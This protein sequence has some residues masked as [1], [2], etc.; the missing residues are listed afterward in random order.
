MTRGPDDVKMTGKGDAA[1]RE[2]KLL[3]ALR[4]ERLEVPP[5]WLMRQAGRYLPEYRELRARAGSFL[6]LCYNPALAAEVTLQP[7]TRFGLDAAI[8]FSDILILPHA[9]GQALRFDEGR[10]PVLEPI[11]DSAALDNLRTEDI[12]ARLG[13]VYEA[14]RRIAVALPSETAFIGFAGAPWT[15]AT[16]MVEGSGSRDFFHAKGW[17]YR[18]PAGF[19]RLIDLLVA[20]TADHLIAQID[21]GVEVVQIFESWAAVLADTAF[22]RWSLAPVAEIARRVKAVHPDVPVIVFPRGAGYH[23]ARLLADPVIDALSIDTAV[24][25]GWAAATL[26][27]LGAVQGNLDPIALL[28]GGAALESEA[29]AIIAALGAGPFVFN[30]GHGVVP[31][32]PPDHVARLVEIV[33]GG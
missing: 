7:I 23:G 24:P 21:A 5:I 4:G 25:P 19:Q 29:R 10:G 11:R 18:D 20:V 33:R 32:T 26:Q 27:P 1:R 13:A 16:Y 14:V 8:L 28:T 31:A 3:R 2:K 22:Q 17:A 9:L 6:D 15:V 30:L 12:A